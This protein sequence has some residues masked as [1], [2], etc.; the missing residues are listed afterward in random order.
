MPGYLVKITTLTGW[1]SFSSSL[2]L[3][4]L[5]QLDC[6][7]QTQNAFNSRG[8]LMSY[9]L[10]CS[11][12]VVLAPCVLFPSTTLFVCGRVSISSIGITL[13]SFIEA[14]DLQFIMNNN[15]SQ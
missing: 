5:L 7:V 14:V 11:Q 10:D 9:D 1:E 8:D 15:A 4:K 2:S 13:Q 3:Q 6:V 12:R